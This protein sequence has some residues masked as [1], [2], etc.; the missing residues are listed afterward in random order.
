MAELGAIGT[1]AP[2]RMVRR[3]GAAALTL[4]LVVGMA[5]AAGA[6]DAPAGTGPIS[7]DPDQPGCGAVHPSDAEHYNRATMDR[8]D[9]WLGADATGQV[10]L[11]DGRLLWLM[12][13]TDWGTRKA[14]GSYAAGWATSTNSAFVQVGGCLESLRTRADFIDKPGDADLYW[15]LDGWVDGDDLY[16]VMTK[17]RITGAAFGFQ[18]AGH[19]VVR[20]DAHTFAFEG[21]WPMPDR[22]RDWGSSVER[23]GDLLYWFGRTPTE[24]PGHPG[25]MFLARSHVA[26]PLEL[27]YRT[28]TGWSNSPSAAVP[29][30]RRPT[31]SNA[32]F[33]RLPD[34]RWAASFKDSEFAGRTIEADVALNPW[35]PWARL[36]P[37]VDAAPLT[38]DEITYGGYL[39]HEI[40]W[41]TAG[42]VLVKWSHNS[43][44]PG[45]VAAGETRYRPAFATVSTGVFDRPDAHA[46]VAAQRNYARHVHRQFLGREP[47]DAWADFW[48][49]D[50]NFG[51]SRATLTST[52]ARSDEWLTRQLDLVYL[53]ALGRRTD[54]TGRATWTRYVRDGGRITDVAAKVYASPEFYERSGGTDRGFVTE[55][56]RKILHREPDSRGLDNWVTHLRQGRSRT[57]VAEGFYGSYESRS[58]RVHS[59][60]QQLLGRSAD[61]TGM[62]TWTSALQRMDDVRLAETLARSAEFF[63]RAQR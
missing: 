43:M 56:Y 10:D 2:L 25:H 57:W 3:V 48:A 44:K 61:P 53:A 18:S 41:S 54:A 55:L 31:P 63:N 22:A 13:D 11:G 52:V 4:G 24:A 23:V 62:R 19:E 27:T 51:V 58:Q 34:G 60:Y 8:D 12:G 45:A 33:T 29:V 42:T 15:P 20:L 59:L 21:R 50:L 16:V 6:E 28:A 32:S 5:P 7:V 47:S 9:S 35:G 40:G 46:A 26:A 49:N 1:T 17:V 14:D 37:I 38:K 36:G 30:H 39:A